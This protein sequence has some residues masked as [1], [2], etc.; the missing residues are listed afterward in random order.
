MNYRFR[1]A[2]RISESQAGNDIQTLVDL[3]L[4]EEASVLKEAWNRLVGLIFGE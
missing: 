2:H 1:V 4:S 3:F